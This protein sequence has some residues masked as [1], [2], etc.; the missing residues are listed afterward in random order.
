MT[1]FKIVRWSFGKH[2]IACLGLCL[3]LN[4][5]ATFLLPTNKAV[6]IGII[7]GIDGPMSIHLSGKLLNLILQNGALLLVLIITLFLY[8]PVKRLIESGPK[9]N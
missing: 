9:Q 5:L 3:L 7:G 8:K 6:S 2:A 1:I 4:I